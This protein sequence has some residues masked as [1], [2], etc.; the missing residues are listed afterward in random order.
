MTFRRVRLVCLAASLAIGCAVGGNH[1]HVVTDSGSGNDAGHPSND[2]YVVPYDAG[3]G[4]DAYVVGMDAGGHDA[5]QHDAGMSDAGTRDAGMRDAGMPDGGMPDAGMDDVGPPDAVFYDGGPPPPCTT[6]HLVISELRSRGV[7]GASDE[8]I[9]L[10]NPTS[11]AIVL[12]THWHLS[13]RSYDVTGFTVRWT[14]AGM[15]IPAHG[16]FLV[17]GSAYAG[18]PTADDNLGS[19]IKDAGSVELLHDTTI[20]DAVCYAFD[21]ASAAM[22]AT[23]FNCEGSLIPNNQSPTSNTDSSLERLPGGAAGNCTDTDDNVSDFQVITPSIPQSTT[24]ATTP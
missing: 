17:T 6:T 21:S 13:A 10:Y 2:A 22:M 11:A 7:A 24:S 19:G 15:S 20:V 18:P 5:G 14:G 16:H 23:G 8:F 9:E 1:P 12:D 3:P 4:N